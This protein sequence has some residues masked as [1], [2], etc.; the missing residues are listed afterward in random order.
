MDGDIE[1][2]VGLFVEAHPRASIDRILSFLCELHRAQ[3]ALV[4]SPTLGGAMIVE[5]VHT[6]R[7]ER[8]ATFSTLWTAQHDAVESGQVVEGDDHVLA[9]LSSPQEFVG[10]LFLDAPQDFR[11]H[12][13]DVYLIALGKALSAAHA[14]GPEI[15]RGVGLDQGALL[16]DMLE[17]HEWNIARVAK[18]AGVTRRTIYLRMDRYGISRKIVPKVLKPLP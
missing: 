2:L 13:L 6:M 4:G 12:G 10:V 18:E 15:L 8:L 16:R 3:G 11:R 1:R 17:R 14:A 5:A 7:A 9:P